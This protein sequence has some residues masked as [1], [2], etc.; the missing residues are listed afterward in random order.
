MTVYFNLYILRQQAGGR[1]TLNQMV[2][3]ILQI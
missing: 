1:K 3:S 2:A